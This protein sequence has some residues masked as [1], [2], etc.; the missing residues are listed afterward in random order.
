MDAIALR[1]LQAP[2]KQRYRDRLETTRVRARLEARLDPAALACRVGGAART[3]VAGLHPA[4]GGDGNRAC[5]AEL[6]PEAL[7]TGDGVTLCIVATVMGSALREGR[8]VAEGVWDARGT[9]GVDKSVPVGLTES[10]LFFELETVADADRLKCLV[11]VTERYC[12]IFQT[13]RA[14][15]PVVGS[16]AP[17]R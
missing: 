2:L 4:A 17:P 5:A 3:V 9:L 6:L 8:I 10:S 13:L 11:A 14:H 1:T 16:I 7:A 15:P 12:V